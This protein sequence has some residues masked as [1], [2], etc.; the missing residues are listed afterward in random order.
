MK[1][2]RNFNLTDLL[3]ET[4]LKAVLYQEAVILYIYIF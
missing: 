4:A 3:I 2:Q 1:V